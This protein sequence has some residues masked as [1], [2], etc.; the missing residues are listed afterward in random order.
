MK[1]I[2]IATLALLSLTAFG[3]KKKAAA[4]AAGSAAPAGSAAAPAPAAKPVAKDDCPAGATKVA[5]AGFCITLPAPYKLGKIEGTPPGDLT[6]HFPKDEESYNDMVLMA[7][8]SD[9][10]ETT[11]EDINRYA[12]A[13]K[14]DVVD[15]GDLL[16]GKG[17]YALSGEKGGKDG[18]T[19]M[20]HVQAAKYLIKCEGASNG[21]PD[22]FKAQLEICKTIT[23]IGG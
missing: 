10:L 2:S 12:D 13:S 11:K 23:P 9:K 19:L 18:A 21:K 3:C 7:S 4:P 22:G 14:Y 16:G 20:L 6:I 17:A 1:N 8:A 5:D 15:H